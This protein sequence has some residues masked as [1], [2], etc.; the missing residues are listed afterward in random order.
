MP[1]LVQEYWD[2]WNEFFLTHVSTAL[3]PGCSDGSRAN[4]SSICSSSCCYVFSVYHRYERA[5]I[6]YAA[7]TP[8]IGVA[9]APGYMKDAR[10]PDHNS[11]NFIWNWRFLKGTLCWELCDTFN[12][13]EV[14]DCFAV[15][16]FPITCVSRWSMQAPRRLFVGTAR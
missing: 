10:R 3:V 12:F 4:S 14:S 16:F 9:H 8:E 1:C 11:Y 15:V 7:E 2:C 5:R 6:L 13:S